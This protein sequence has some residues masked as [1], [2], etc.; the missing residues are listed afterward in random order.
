MSNGPRPTTPWESDGEP[1]RS[2]RWTALLVRARHGDKGAFDTLMEEAEPGVRLQA[3][4]VLGD[5]ALA[6]DVTNETFEKVWV[7]LASYDEELSN[8]RTWIHLIAGRL[9]L[10]YLER[11]TR[12]RRTEVGG[13]DVLFGGAGDEDAGP[14]LEPEDPAEPAPPEEA[15]RPLRRAL[16]EEALQRYHVEGLCYEE[17]A[18]RLRCSVK[19]VGPRLTR[20][21][22]RLRQVLHPEAEP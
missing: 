13:F 20:A 3:F 17:I 9:T 18:E 1:N 15:D 19:A 8:A 6:D 10:D 2:S 14:G 7:N 21:R 16:V 4:R 22:E 11:R 12:Q 5:A